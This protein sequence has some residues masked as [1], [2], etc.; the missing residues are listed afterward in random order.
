VKVRVVT[1]AQE[2]ASLATAWSELADAADAPIHATPFWALPWWRHRGRGHLRVSVVEGSAGIVALMPLHSRVRAGREVLRFLGDDL[3]SVS[4]AVVAPGHEDA[5]VALWE[6]LAGGSDRRLD[7]RRHRLDGLGLQPLWQTAA[8]RW[9][10]VV[11][12]VCP[13]VSGSAPG[14]PETVEDYLSNRGSRLRRTLSR[15]P[16]LAADAGLEVRTELL[17]DLADVQRL[18]PELRALWDAAE[19]DNPRTHFLAGDLAAFTDEVLAGAAQQ[20]RLALPVTWIGPQLAGAA[21]GYR[22]GQTWSYSGP[23]FDPA[24]QRYSPGH[25]TLRRLTE[26]VLG[27][28]ER[29]DL[30]LGGQDY[31]WQWATSSYDVADVL[32]AGSES[33]LQW[34]QLRAYR[35]R[36][37]LTHR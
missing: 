34:A 21:F 7:L 2:L 6:E 37:R 36:Q 11:S 31:K 10:A 3:G 30:L 19:A 12:N 20:G 33:G 27:R 13:V 25:L 8:V 17:T 18:M 28:G 24:L 23:R 26:H 4:G 14:K 32:A 15:A 1:D 29:L 16:R 9:S 5:A 22:V 35:A